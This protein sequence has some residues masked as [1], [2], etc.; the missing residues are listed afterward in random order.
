MIGPPGGMMD[1]GEMPEE[2]AKRELLEET[3][4]EA[5]NLKLW[6]SLQPSFR[7]EWAVYVFIAK[8]C[9][10]VGDVQN[11]AKEKIRVREVS[12]D[13]FVDIA[14]SS[15]FYNV[16]IRFEVLEAKSDPTKMKELRELFGV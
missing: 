2:A 11:D 7:L 8:D 16:N 3:G 10:M 12:F 1:E 5:T 13:D 6:I 4:C 9:R 14:A 15:D